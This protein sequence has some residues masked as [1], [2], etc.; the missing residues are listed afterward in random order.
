MGSS[1]S[2]VAAAYGT[3]WEEVLGNFPEPAPVDFPVGCQ[4]HKKQ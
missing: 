1:A 4:L 2:L 3:V